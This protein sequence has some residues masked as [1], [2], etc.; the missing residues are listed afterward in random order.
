MS[1]RGQHLCCFLRDI[2]YWEQSWHATSC[3][4]TCIFLLSCGLVQSC[5]LIETKHHFVL[6]LTSLRE[7]IQAVSLK[8]CWCTRSLP[9]VRDSVQSVL[10]WKW[11]CSFVSLYYRVRNATPQMP[12]SKQNRW[13]LLQHLKKPNETLSFPCTDPPTPFLFRWYSVFTSLS[14]SVPP[15]S[16]FN[17]FL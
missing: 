11:I 4:T 9:Q 1:T 3:Y 15:L 12:G 16:Y 17:N 8:K 7:S 6:S 10:L 2:L 13:L 5:W 14:P